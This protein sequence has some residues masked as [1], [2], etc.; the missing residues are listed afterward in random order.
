MYSA[1]LQPLHYKLKRAEGKGHHS[2]A[3][4]PLISASS[5]DSDI[6][7]PSSIT[8]SSGITEMFAPRHGKVRE[9]AEGV[10]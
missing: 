4:G 5:S 1:R 10:N 2:G 3:E 6:P 8:L 7:L 9:L